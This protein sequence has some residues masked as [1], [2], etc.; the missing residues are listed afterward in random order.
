MCN[1]HY[2][3]WEDTVYY[4]GQREVF[5]GMNRHQNSVQGLT[6]LQ[7]Y[8][9][10]FLTSIWCRKLWTRSTPMYSNSYI[11]E[12]VL[13][14]SGQWWKSGSRWLVEEMYSASTDVKQD[15][16]FLA[17][18]RNGMTYG[19]AL[20]AVAA[21]I[22]HAAVYLC[23]TSGHCCVCVDMYR[24]TVEQHVFLYMWNVVPLGSVWEHVTINLVQSQFQVWQASV[25]LLIKS[26]LLG[27]LLDKKTCQEM[28]CDYQRKTTW[29]R[30]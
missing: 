6:T 28:P 17:C 26:N 19:Q 5:N 4:S 20:T 18:S 2:F 12:P 3:L 22:I 14:P 11:L 27:P 30:G 23:L 1:S 15:C 21:K 13:F 16:S 10:Y 25:N 8:F 29:K 24:H 9:N 7:V